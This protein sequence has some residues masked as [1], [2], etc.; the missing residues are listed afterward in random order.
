MP[1]QFTCINGTCPDPTR[2]STPTE[3]E[4]IVLRL[5]PGHKMAV[6]WKCGACG[7]MNPITQHAEPAVRDPGSYAPPLPLPSC[8]TFILKN[9]LLTSMA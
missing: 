1:Q 4:N 3:L 6:N 9:E 8:M 2:D 5:A 7:T